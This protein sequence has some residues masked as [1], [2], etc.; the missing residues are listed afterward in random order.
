MCAAPL[1]PPRGNRP[2]TLLEMVVVCAI[3]M[4]VVALVVPRLGGGGLR[5]AAESALSEIRGA[6]QQ[7]ATRARITGQPYQLA[8][9]PEEGIFQVAPL[10]NPLDRDWHPATLPALRGESGRGAIV[11]LIDSYRVPDGVEWTE[12]PDGGED[13]GG[14]LFRFFPDGEATGP[15]LAWKMHG[16]SYR[17]IMDSVQGKAT[18]LEILEN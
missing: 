13:L 9:L 1:H 11:Q 7:T 18:I 10:E 4:L 8:L 14:I 6:F 2:Y 3:V 15:E 12:L 5:M 17:L 16:R